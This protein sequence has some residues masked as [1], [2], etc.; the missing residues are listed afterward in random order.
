MARRY[1]RRGRLVNMNEIHQIQQLLSTP[2]RN[3]EQCLAFIHFLKKIV[4]QSPEFA[5]YIENDLTKIME[6]HWKLVR[7]EHLKLQEI[8]QC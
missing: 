6:D 1:Y 4:I 5:R 8:K 2:I 7:S 3:H